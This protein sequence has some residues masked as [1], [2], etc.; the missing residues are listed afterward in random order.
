MK[1]LTHEKANPSAVGERE[2]VNSRQVPS[3]ELEKVTGL[4]SF[5]ILRRSLIECFTL[6]DRRG[7]PGKSVYSRQLAGQ[8]GSSAYYSRLLA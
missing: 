5:F 2:K 6:H 4:M 7:F 1:T 8:V 3:L